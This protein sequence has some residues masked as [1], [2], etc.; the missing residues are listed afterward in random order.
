MAE[1]KSSMYVYDCVDITFKFKLNSDIF[2]H[3]VICVPFKWSS[4]IDK[5]YLSLYQNKF[6]EDKS[7]P[8]FNFS[9]KASYSLIFCFNLSF[10]ANVKGW[11]SSVLKKT[12]NMNTQKKKILKRRHPSLNPQQGYQR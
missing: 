7:F 8:L 2:L 5:I 12:K 6:I 9:L 4:F 3:D 11:I 10:N 1:T